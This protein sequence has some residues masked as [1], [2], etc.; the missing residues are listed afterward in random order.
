MTNNDNLIATRLSDKMV[1][2]IKKDVESGEFRS[3]ADWVRTA[4]YEFYKARKGDRLGGG[5]AL[6]NPFPGCKKIFGLPNANNVY[7]LPSFYRKF[8][9]YVLHSLTQR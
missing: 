1:E 9:K 6:T 3:T 5:G 2:F 7:L 4:C 8:Y